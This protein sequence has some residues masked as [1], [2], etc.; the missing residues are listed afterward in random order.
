MNNWDRDNLNFI[1]NTTDEAFSDW[2]LQ[3]DSDDID[4]ALELI[5]KHREEIYL[6]EYLLKCDNVEI[7]NTKEASTVIPFFFNF[8][9]NST[10]PGIVF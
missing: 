3:A 4:Y 7:L 2:M 5:S 10:R 1:L 9:T 8:R 6:K